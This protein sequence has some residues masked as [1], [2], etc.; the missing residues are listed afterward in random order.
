MKFK[1]L[2]VRIREHKVLG[3]IDRF[4]TNRV[5]LNILQN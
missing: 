2:A 3:T 5:F 1:E 4:L